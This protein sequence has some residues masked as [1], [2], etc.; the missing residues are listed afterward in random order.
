LFLGGAWG[1]I[2]AAISLQFGV[3]VSFDSVEQSQTFVDLC[4]IESY[5]FI[6]GCPT[7][8]LEL[9]ISAVDI[10]QGAIPLYVCL[11]GLVIWRVRVFASEISIN[12]MDCRIKKHSDSPIHANRECGIHVYC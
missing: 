9:P 12:Q 4:G 3:N 8:V 11:S 7:P 6:S 2:G 10:G 1:V 5:R